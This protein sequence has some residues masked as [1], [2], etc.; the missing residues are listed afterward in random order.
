MS[1]F[2]G[3]SYDGLPEMAKSLPV[4]LEWTTDMA[5]DPLSILR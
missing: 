3:F 4:A 5:S 1:H 2:Y